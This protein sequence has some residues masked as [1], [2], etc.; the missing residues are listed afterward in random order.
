VPSPNSTWE[1][2]ASSVFHEMISWA[3]CCW[4]VFDAVGRMVP[5]T[6]RLLICGGL[7]SVAVVND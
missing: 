7:V 6:L 3:S 1:V 4:E 5:S 2:A